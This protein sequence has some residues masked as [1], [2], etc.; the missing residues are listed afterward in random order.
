MKNYLIH[1]TANEAALRT[2]LNQDDYIDFLITETLKEINKEIEQT[3]EAGDFEN[4]YYDYQPPNGVV[5][6]P[7]KE[8]LE[9]LGY[10]FKFLRKIPEEHSSK[11]AY[12]NEYKIS[13]K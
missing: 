6:T 9:S 11:Y 10:T 8:V 2:K 4:L 12:G 7:V 5:M 13:W 1:Y 3:I